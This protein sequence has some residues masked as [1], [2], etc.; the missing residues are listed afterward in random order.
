MTFR[1]KN[2]K[3]EKAVV[4][5]YQKIESSVLSHYKSI[6]DKFV[7]TFLAEEGET[8]AEA[9]ERIKNEAETRENR[10]NCK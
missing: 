9:K 5:G 7:G 3:I 10:R 8:P 2:K 4:G 6:E 1:E